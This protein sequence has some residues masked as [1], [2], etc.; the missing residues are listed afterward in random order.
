MSEGWRRRLLEESF[1]RVNEGVKVG[2]LLPLVVKS[3]SLL[4]I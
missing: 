1:L 2:I 3:G 4:T